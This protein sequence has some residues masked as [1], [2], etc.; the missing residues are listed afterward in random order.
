L[1]YPRSKRDRKDISA[2][3]PETQKQKSGK[4]RRSSAVTE[5][6]LLEEKHSHSINKGSDLEYIKAELTRMNALMKVIQETTRHIDERIYILES[7]LDRK[8]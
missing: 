1:G 7:K 8:S 4:K 3:K 5:R 2:A 6:E